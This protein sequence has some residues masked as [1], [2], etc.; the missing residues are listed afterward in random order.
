MNRTCIRVLADPI[1]ISLEKAI[2]LSQTK[3]KLQYEIE[4]DTAAIEDS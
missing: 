3:N 2:E 4:I 1:Q